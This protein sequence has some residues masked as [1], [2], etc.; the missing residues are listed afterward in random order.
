MRYKSRTIKGTTNYAI[1]PQ[2]KR[3]GWREDCLHGYEGPGSY[4]F[5]QVCGERVYPKE[6][7]SIKRAVKRHVDN[8]GKPRN[9]PDK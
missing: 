9:G 6:G 5:C 3:S 8:H 4:A 1:Y 2:A 7:E